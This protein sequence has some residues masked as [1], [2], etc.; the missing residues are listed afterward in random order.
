MKKSPLDLEEISKQVQN[1]KLSAE[2]GAKLIAEDLHRNPNAYFLISEDEDIIS[3][4][5][6]KIIEIAPYVFKN[7]K[8]NLC[9]FKTYIVS[10][11]KYQ[12]LSLLRIRKIKSKK[13]H[14]ILRHMEL[15]YEHKLS[16][17][18]NDE[19]SFKIAHM[20]NFVPPAKDKISWKERHNK[21]YA[22]KKSSPEKIKNLA[23][24]WKN[25]SS[26]KARTALILALKSSYY[27]T[28]EN[29]D[30][31]CDYCE[32]SKNIMKDA[33]REFEQ[34][35][36][37]RKK[38]VEKMQNMRNKS[39]SKLIQI[40]EEIKKFDDNQEDTSELVKKY[41]YHTENWNKRNDKLKSPGFK[42]CPTNKDVG[43]ILG[44]CERQVGNYIKNAENLAEEMKNDILSTEMNTK[45]S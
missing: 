1:K 15:S 33:I 17:Y 4:L 34:K 27:M 24:Y 22:A 32:L 37:T 18:E 21:K 43:K 28:E 42:I 35:N 7:Y 26:T 31:V 39:F 16:Q 38:K 10:F 3:E 41:K 6:L 29:I 30:S 23:Q 9:S 5:S 45:N 25:R 20:R 12:T 2:D 19:E 36:S 44:I 11:L 40:Q 13:E 8:K 14:A